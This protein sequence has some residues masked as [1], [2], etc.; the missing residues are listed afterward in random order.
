MLYIVHNDTFDIHVDYNMF[1]TIQSTTV[2]CTLVK[3]KIYI[4]CYNI[5]S[6]LQIKNS[7]FLHEICVVCR[8]R[9]RRLF[10]IILAL[11]D[12]NYILN[13]FVFYSIDLF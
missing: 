5:T 2:D 6:I 13:I 12:Y 4:Q 7:L 1:Y 11:Y 10:K 8:C 3:V 9:C